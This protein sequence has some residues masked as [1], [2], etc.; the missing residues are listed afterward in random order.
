MRKQQQAKKKCLMSSTL[1]RGSGVYPI[2][3][4]ESN[5]ANNHQFLS[6]SINKIL[7]KPF[8]V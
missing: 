1:E 7:I 5:L 3:F 6:L 4:S 2:I 8:R